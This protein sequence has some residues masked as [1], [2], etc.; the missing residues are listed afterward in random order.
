MFAV[1]LHLQLKKLLVYLEYLECYSILFYHISV[2]Y[3]Q[4]HHHVH[5]ADFVWVHFVEHLLHLLK[6][7]PHGD[8]M[9]PT[10]LNE[11]LKCSREERSTSLSNM[12]IQQYALTYYMTILKFV[13]FY[14]TVGATFPILVQVTDLAVVSLAGTVSI[15]LSCFE[16]R[17]RGTPHEI[18]HHSLSLVLLER[19]AG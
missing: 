5:G 15:C 14:Y 1:L 19:T 11:L 9:R 4:V 18:H 17:Q 3:Y 2:S 13:F 6:R 16:F 10:L 7:G 12:L 8:I